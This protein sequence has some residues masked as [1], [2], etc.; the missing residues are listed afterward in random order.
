M[1]IQEERRCNLSFSCARVGAY[2]LVG[3]RDVI[4]LCRSGFYNWWMVP[5][6]PNVALF[7]F[8]FYLGFGKQGS[9]MEFC[10]F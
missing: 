2:S 1:V 5:E 7:H 4:T 6:I 3:S 8:F 10:A 9:M